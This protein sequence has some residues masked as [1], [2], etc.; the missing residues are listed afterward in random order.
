VAAVTRAGADIA[1]VT[2]ALRTVRDPELDESIV[3]LGFVTATEVH[4]GQAVVRLRLP[5]FFCAPNFAFLMVADAHDSVV[6]VPGISSVVIVL[7]DHFASD[8]INAGVSAGAGFVGSFP[9]HAEGELDELRLTFRRKAHVA[10]MERACRGLMERGWS[11]DDL[12]RATIADLPTGLTRDGLVRRRAEVGLPAS[13]DV[14]VLVDDDG[15]PVPH[16]QVALRLR[17]GR[18]VGVSI[19]GN[20]HICRGLLAARYPESATTPRAH[21]HPVPE[22]AR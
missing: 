14:P 4:D 21:E 3:D 12:P 8:Q 7:E 11:V 5:T 2:D 6:A 22:E 19:E 17:M 13:A 9:E 18:T 10:S 15:R 20:T 1:A 16:D